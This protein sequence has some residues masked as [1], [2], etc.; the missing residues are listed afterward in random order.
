V[1]LKEMVDRSITVDLSVFSFDKASTTFSVEAST[2]GLQPGAIPDDVFIKNKKG[3]MVKFQH[4]S[5]N[6]SDTEKELESMEYHSP[7]GKY[8]ILIFND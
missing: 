5:N 3:Q 7:K 8:R 2:I 1:L 4:Y 6:Y